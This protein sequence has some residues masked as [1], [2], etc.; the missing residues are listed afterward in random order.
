MTNTQAVTSYLNLPMLG[1]RL[2][3]ASSDITQGYRFA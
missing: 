3:L 2:E 1:E